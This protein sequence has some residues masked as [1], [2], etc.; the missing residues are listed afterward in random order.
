MAEPRYPME[1]LSEQIQSDLITYLDGFSNEIIDGVCKI[2]ADRF[3][4][5]YE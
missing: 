1:E 3:K 4:G 2:I 5:T